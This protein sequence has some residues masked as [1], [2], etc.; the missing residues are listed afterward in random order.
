MP[1]LHK[2][3]QVSVAWQEMYEEGF[4][5]ITN[6]DLCL[7]VIKA[8]Q[9][10]YRDKPGHLPSFVRVFGF[11]AQFFVVSGFRA[12]LGFRVLGPSRSLGFRPSFRALLGFRV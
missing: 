12:L 8:M 3:P 1:P 11:R 9:E 7:T 5:S 6:I 10:K 2:E 4:H